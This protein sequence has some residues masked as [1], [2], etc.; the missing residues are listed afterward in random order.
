MGD[1][2]ISLITSEFADPFNVFLIIKPSKTKCTVA[3]FCYWNN[4]ILDRE[5]GNLRFP[6]E[7]RQ[8]AATGD[9]QRI[10]S[11]S[12]GWLWIFLAALLLIAIGI[13]KR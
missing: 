8:L 1:G 5:P 3:G 10:T 13:V 2:D 11:Y 4:G 9:H 6:F 12:Y 7:S